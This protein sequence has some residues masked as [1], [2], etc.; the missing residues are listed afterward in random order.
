MRYK[1]LINGCTS[2]GAIVK[3]MFDA[4]QFYNSVLFSSLGYEMNLFFL[5]LTIFKEVLCG[6]GNKL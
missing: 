6:K 2:E 4:L 3:L 5:F 1:F